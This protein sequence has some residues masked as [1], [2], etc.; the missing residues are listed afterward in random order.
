MM[1]GARLII[2][3]EVPTGRKWNLTRIKELTGAS[4]NMKIRAR[5]MNKDFFEFTPKGKLFLTGNDR[6][7]LEKVD[8]AIRRR[9]RLLPFTVTIEEKDKILDLA[10]QLEANGPASWLGSLKLMEYHH[11]ACPAEGRRGGQR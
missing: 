7:A 8:N 4:A 9:L 5:F 10:K 11:R 6:P 3:Q 2:G 1:Q